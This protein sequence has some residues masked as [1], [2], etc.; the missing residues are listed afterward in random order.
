[1]VN[2]L[3]R[4]RNTEYCASHRAQGI[5]IRVT[6]AFERPIIMPSCR[7]RLIDSGHAEAANLAT[8]VA[9]D[10]PAVMSRGKMSASPEGSRRFQML[11]PIPC[12][13]SPRARHV[14]R[15][16]MRSYIPRLPTRLLFLAAYLLEL[17]MRS[18]RH[19]RCRANNAARLYGNVR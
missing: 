10:Q 5:I 6:D 11:L 3:H 16:G 4:Y 18:R 1:M 12:R 7:R 15:P 14:L 9:R 13:T 17:G 2:A 19:V 8:P